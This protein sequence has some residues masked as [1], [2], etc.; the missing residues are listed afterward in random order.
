MVTA[1]SCILSKNVEKI[2]IKHSLRLTVLAGVEKQG[3]EGDKG[4]ISIRKMP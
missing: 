3:R 4:Y 1:I 2:A